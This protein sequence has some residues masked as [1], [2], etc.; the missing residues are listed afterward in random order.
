MFSKDESITYKRGNSRKRF[1]LTLKF[2]I[3]H[4]MDIQTIFGHILYSNST[5][6]NQMIFLQEIQQNLISYRS[7]ADLQLIVAFLALLCLSVMLVS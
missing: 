1:N 4:I 2:L 7:E 3:N 5:N 6:I